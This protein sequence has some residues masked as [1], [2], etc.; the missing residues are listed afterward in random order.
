MSGKTTK[1]KNVNNQVWNS[2]Y[3]LGE[4]FKKMKPWEYL[5]NLDMVQIDMPD[6]EIGY[7]VVMGNGGSMYGFSLYLGEQG[8]KILRRMQKQMEERIS[9]EHIIMEQ[10]CLN[11]WLSDKDEVPPEQMFILDTLG[12]RYRG[13][14]SWIYFERYEKGFMPYIYSVEDAQKC[15]KY[16]EKLIE[17]LPEIKIAMKGKEFSY[18]FGKSFFAYCY[19]LG[20]WGLKVKEYPN[21]EKLYIM[22]QLAITPETV[23]LKNSKKNHQIWE[24]DCTKIMDVI[25]DGGK[26]EKP[27]MPIA[28]FV[29]NSKDGYVLYHNLFEPYTVMEEEISSALA[30]AIVENGRPDKIIVSDKLMEAAVRDVCRICKIELVIGTVTQCH[31]N[32]DS[33]GEFSDDELMR[34]MDLIGIDP[35]IAKEKAE[36]SQQ[37]FMKYAED[38]VKKKFA[39]TPSAMME[40]LEDMIG[41]DDEFYPEFDEPDLLNEN[42]DGTF[43]ME[44]A[45]FGLREKTYKT[46]KE[47]IQAIRDAFGEGTID[48]DEQEDLE[49]MIA[50]DWS[51]DANEL[52]GACRKEVLLSMAD[53]LGL[54]VDKG[55]K[56][57][58]LSMVIIDKLYKDPSIVS[59]L[60][61]QN[62]KRALKLLV[63]L[64]KPGTGVY[65]SDFPYDSNALTGLVEKGLADVV[66]YYD[67]YSLEV[68]IRPIKQLEKAIKKL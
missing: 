66:T 13:K 34:F 27:Y 37:E 51:Y 52:F 20:K 24:Y 30:N 53:K 2:L 36:I 28:A 60:L 22:P 8:Y 58:T 61:S 1:Q 12:R 50:A 62:E 14:N 25:D 32:Y 56:K 49:P 43:G 26:Y 68:E 67:E 15:K 38:Q 65:S 41:L 35:D 46:Q 39:S 7:F 21:K 59:G 47:K 5:S 18:D 4:Q 19:D 23:K 54:L 11:M 33:M 64:I 10:D 45:D 63:S 44:E 48:Q 57:E 55:Y 31:K 6:G 17:S 42:N 40:F 16:L 3:D 29:V 9:E